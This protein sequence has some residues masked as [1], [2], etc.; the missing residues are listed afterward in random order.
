MKKNLFWLLS[1]SL[2]VVVSC[3][4]KTA[5]QQAQSTSPKVVNLAIWANYITPENIQDFEKKTGIKV[6]VS[7]YASNEELLAKI[8]A[9]ASGYDIAVPSDYMVK[10]MTELELLTPLDQAK[11]PNAK[12][13]DPKVM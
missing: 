8:Q 9:G 13:L 1:L 5:D 4:R 7:N 12:L 10:V 11:I 2:L 6:Q 3:T